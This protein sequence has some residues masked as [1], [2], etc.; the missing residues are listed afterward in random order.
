MV[1]E[2]LWPDNA[3][4]WLNLFI[5]MATF[6][7]YIL[8]GFVPAFYVAV[9]KLFGMPLLQRWSN[10]V[11][12]MLY[13]TKAVFG[14]IT[15]QYEPYFRSGKGAYWLGEPLMPQDYTDISPKYKTKIDEIKDQYEIIATKEVKTKKEEKQM[16]SLLKQQKRL[17]KEILAVKPVNQLL[18]FSHAINQPIHQMERRKSKVDEILNNNPNP[19]KMA[20]HG[21]WLMQN[22]KLHFHRHYQIVIDKTGTQYVMVPVKDRQQFSIGFWHSI[23]IIK[24]TEVEVETDQEL[25]GS[26]GG[27]KKRLMQTALTTHIILEQIK[28]V[29]D[30]QNFSASRAFMLLKRRARIESSFASWITGSVDPKLLMALIVLLGGAAAIFLVLHMGAGGGTPAP[31]APTNGIRP[32]L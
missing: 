26:N 16:L 12:I 32:I 8:I 28:E 17:E 11:V 9:V 21:V 15:Q 23:G 25:G 10:E 3:P 24:Q 5:W 2:T 13:P 4:W 7:W 18:I 1:V 6:W 20:G 30:Y 19:K 22:P 27:G 14:K 29:Q 31:T